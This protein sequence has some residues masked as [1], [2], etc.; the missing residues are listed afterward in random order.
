MTID[1][2]VLHTLTVCASVL[3][4]FAAAIGTAWKLVTN[5]VWHM[6]QDIID[7]ADQNRKDVVNEIQQANK[8]NVIA[9]E[10]SAV[11]IVSAIVRGKE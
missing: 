8:D 5:H 6:K 1:K 10:R 4:G 11:Q 3:S 2:D 7:N 9:I